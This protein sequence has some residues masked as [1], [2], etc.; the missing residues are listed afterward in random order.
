MKDLTVSVETLY[1]A[2]TM[3]EDDTVRSIA[4]WN[5]WWVNG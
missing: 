5:D 1:D 3:T 2:L 4:E